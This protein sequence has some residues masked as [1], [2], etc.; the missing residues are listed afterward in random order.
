MS[1]IKIPNTISKLETS[2]KAT[3]QGCHID[4]VITQTGSSHGWDNHMS[5]RWGNHQSHGTR[6]K[7][8]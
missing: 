2:P 4:G 5:H 3:L 8:H 7:P 1:A 6:A